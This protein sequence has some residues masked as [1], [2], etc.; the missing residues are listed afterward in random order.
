MLIFVGFL[1]FQILKRPD[2]NCG[3]RKT[4]FRLYPLLT[5]NCKIHG[6]NSF[7]AR[8]VRL[9]YNDNRSILI[10]LYCRV[11]RVL[12][13]WYIFINV[14]KEAYYY[15]KMCFIR[16][17]KIFNG[18]FVKYLFIIKIFVGIKSLLIF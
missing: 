5:L 2:L 15:S 12:I 16:S 18:I 1:F 6:K 11:L 7:Y 10:E 17:F 9:L 4:H 14:I 3:K 13:L 8:I